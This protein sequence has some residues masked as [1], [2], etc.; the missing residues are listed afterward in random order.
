MSKCGYK[1]R[2]QRL[3]GIEMMSCFRTLLSRSPIFNRSAIPNK[4]LV[5]SRILNPGKSPNLSKI[6][7]LNNMRV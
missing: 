4:S 5:P 7:F 2:W 6:S 1:R 3:V